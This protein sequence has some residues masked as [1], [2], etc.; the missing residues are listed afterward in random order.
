MGLVS[1]RVGY[2]AGEEDEPGRL[3]DDGVEG[4]GRSARMVASGGGG[5]D[6]SKPRAVPAAASVACSSTVMFAP[7]TVATLAVER[8]LPS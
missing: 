4:R 5:P 3:V 6:C 7:W 8:L 2:M 1:F